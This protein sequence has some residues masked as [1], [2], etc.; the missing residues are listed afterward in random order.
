M[1]S[2]A[3]SLGMSSRSAR[4]KAERPYTIPKLIILA[5]ERSPASMSSGVTPNISAAVAAERLGDAGVRRETGL[6]PALLRQAE[7]REEDLGQ[8]LRGADRELLP[9]QVPDLAL[10]RDDP[11]LHLP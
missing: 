3:S 6:A 8:L 1:N 9:R 7:L 2:P 4:P 5:F 10:E 11:L